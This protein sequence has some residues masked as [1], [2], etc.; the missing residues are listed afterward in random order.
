MTLQSSATRSFRRFPLTLS[1]LA[2]GLL[3]IPIYAM[4]SRETAEPP[5]SVAMAPVDSAPSAEPGSPTTPVPPDATAPSAEPTSPRPPAPPVATVSPVAS[6]PPAVPAS[7]AAPVPP[8]PPFEGGIADAEFG[9]HAAEAPPPSSAPMARRERASDGSRGAASKAGRLSLV[10]VG[11]GGGGMMEAASAVSG[12]GDAVEAKREWTPPVAAG[13]LTAGAIDDRVDLTKLDELR[14]RAVPLNRELGQRVPD[15][16]AMMPAPDGQSFSRLEVGFVLDTTGSMSDEIQY[17]KAEMH[18][19]AGEIGTEYPQVSQRFALVAYRD[20][21]DEYVV[22]HHDFSELSAFAGHLG[23]EFA[24]GGGDF[25]EAMDQALETASH[26][27]WSTRDAAKLVFLIADAPPHPEGYGTFVHASSALGLKGVSIYPVASSGVDTTSE[28]LMRWAARTTGGQYLFLTDHSGIG[29]AHA[30]PHVDQYVL[31][32]LREHM[33]DMIRAELGSPSTGPISP[34]VIAPVVTPE[35]A[36]APIAP[37]AVEAPEVTAPTPPWWER[38]GGF[39]GILG[40]LFVLG[41]AGDM[42]V[43]TIR[44]RATR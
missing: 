44:R 6:V 8:M 13:Q 30:T 11:A 14:S 12:P 23:Q 5:Q 17:L 31:K 38:H 18:S 29:N 9:G 4:S 35:P 15:H 22:R 42:A 1:A 37:V 25:P 3:A 20:V 21:G 16:K 19:I 10:G 41:F 39:L 26:L 7:P 28:Y 32:P 33:L 27:Q 24:N 43:S 34:P 2:G 36:V 40:G